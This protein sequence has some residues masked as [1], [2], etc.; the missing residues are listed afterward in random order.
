MLCHH[1]LVLFAPCQNPL[2]NSPQM[3]PGLSASCSLLA[4]ACPNWFTCV[5]MSG[6][7]FGLGGFL[8]G[9]TKMRAFRLPI[10]WVSRYTSGSQSWYSTWFRWRV[11]TWVSM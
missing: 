2:Y 9:G 7:T 3:T 5:Q 4:M 8:N 10:W 6:S 1:G 11:S